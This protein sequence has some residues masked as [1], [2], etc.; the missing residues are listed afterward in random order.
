MLFLFV[1]SRPLLQLYIGEE[2][3]TTPGL[4]DAACSYVNTRALSIPTY[5]VTGVLQSALLGARDSVTPLVAILYSTVVNVF[6]DFILVS[7]LKMGLRGAAIATTL[8]QWAST[9][10][11]IGPAREKLVQDHNLGILKKAPRTSAG[12]TGRA[13]L[14]FAAPV[15]TL[16]LGK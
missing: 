5:L 2:A 12:V 8:A 6:G 10:A 16:I 7:R 15:L 1:F 11:L 13:F 3:A 9:I 14:G 4:L